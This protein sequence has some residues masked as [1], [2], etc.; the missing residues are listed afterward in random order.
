M[1]LKFNIGVKTALNKFNTLHRIDDGGG[2]Q[3]L[4]IL[5]SYLWEFL[6]TGGHRI[7][8]IGTLTEHASAYNRK[9]KRIG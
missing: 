3:N 8:T 2:M 4:D 1:Q 6:E 5:G 9:N 7:L